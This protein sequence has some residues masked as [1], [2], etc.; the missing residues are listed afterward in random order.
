MVP[1]RK[2]AVPTFRS[3]KSTSVEA[4]KTPLADADLFGAIKSGKHELLDQLYIQHRSAF[5]TYAQ[6]Q[7]SATE[8]DAAD[9]FQ[10]AVIAFYKNVVTGRLTE[11]TCEIRTYL[12]AIGK[13]LV[14]RKNHHRHREVVTDPVS[15]IGMVDDP[16]REVDL[17]LLNR[18]ENDERRAQLAAGLARLGEPCQQILT[19]FY[20]HRYPIESVQEAVGLPSPGATRIKKMRCLDKLKRVLAT[21]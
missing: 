18:L 9:C 5:L 4:H 8:D 14:Y 7:L 10:D 1:L 16:S 2:S 12:F 11:L 21:Q 20:Y 17:S 6:R 15:G 13:R 3:L 19:L